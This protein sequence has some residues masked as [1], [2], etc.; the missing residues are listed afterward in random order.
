[1]GA[2]SSE[3]SESESSEDSEAFLAGVAFT[4]AALGFSSSEDSSSEDSSDEDVAGFSALAGVFLGSSS[5][6][7]SEDSDSEDEEAFFAGAFE[8]GVAFDDDALAAGFSSS[9]SLSLEEDSLDEDSAL[10][11]E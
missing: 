5:E 4:W 9:L 8:L 2:S 11:Y 10:A 7:S 6:D 3:L 1:M